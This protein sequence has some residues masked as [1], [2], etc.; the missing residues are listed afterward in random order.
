MLALPLGAKIRVEQV[1]ETCGGGASNTS[2]GLS[3]L[4]CDAHFCGV[5]GSDQWGQRLLE[6]FRKEGVDA[7]CTTI[8]ENETTSFSIILSASSGERVILYQAGTNMHLHD[9]N[10][11]REAAA[12]MDWIYLNHIH[13][14][15]T[16]IEDDLIE[17]L[18]AQPKTG[19][20]W[21][22]GGS[23]LALGI[24]EKSIRALLGETDLLVCNKEES[25]LFTGTSTV[26]EA[27]H[28]LLSLG[29]KTVCISDGPRGCIGATAQEQFHC[30]VIETAPVIDTTGAGDAFGTGATWALLQGLPLPEVLRSG[31][32]SATGVIGAMGAQIGLLTDIEMRQRLR[33]TSLDVEKISL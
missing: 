9:A 3:R 4:G 21:N 7:R 16:V 29:V 13:E 11:D 28:A 25:L 18:H 22:P 8:V 27:I 32:I 2:V 10:F 5:V 19:L 20:T 15:S 24:K 33:E 23:Q 14:H 1:I 17:I 6:N 12:G 30:P 26:D 31:T